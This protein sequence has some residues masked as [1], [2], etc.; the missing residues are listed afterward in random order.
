[1]R[2]GVDMDGVLADLDGAIRRH[3]RLAGEGQSFA[4]RVINTL[5]GVV[6]SPT[7]DRAA[8]WDEIRQLDAFWES[9]DEIEPGCVARLADLSRGHEWQ[10]IFLT[11]RP[12]VAGDTAQRQTQRWLQA[13]GFELPSVYVV[14][15]SRGQIAAALDLDV[16]IDDDLENCLDVAAT[17]NARS[18]L[19]CRAPQPPAV[20]GLGIDV[21]S[22][23][24]AGLN[25]LTGS[26]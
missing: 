10:I 2:V 9:L 19:V 25:L 26:P 15:G 17:S 23:L 20:D 18:I 16:V 7:A 3:Q 13:R 14:P 12:E 21:V 24:E 11:R 22:T 5:K 4:G 1:L 8:L 6:M